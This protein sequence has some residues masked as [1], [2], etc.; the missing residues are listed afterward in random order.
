MRVVSES[1]EEVETSICPYCDGKP[2]RN[3]G[4]VRQYRDGVLVASCD[5]SWVCDL[6][7]GDGR[8]D[9]NLARQVWEKLASTA[10]GQA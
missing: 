10:P 6:C 9:R 8:I 3:L 2:H 5:Q 1:A 7:A 4:T